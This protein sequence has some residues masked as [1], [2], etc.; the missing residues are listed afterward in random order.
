M[1]KPKANLLDTVKIAASNNMSCEPFVGWQGRVERVTAEWNGSHWSLP[2]Y[3][4]YFPHPDNR[5]VTFDETEIELVK[6][7]ND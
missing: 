3:A 2:Q 5:T 6:K 1:T 7:A 4:V